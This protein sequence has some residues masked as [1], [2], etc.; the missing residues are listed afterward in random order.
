MK[1]QNICR[2]KL[3]WI[4]SFLHHWHQRLNCTWFTL[5]LVMAQPIPLQP[6]SPNKSHC[7]IPPLHLKFNYASLTL[8]HTTLAFV[9]DLS[10]IESILYLPSDFFVPAYS[11][12]WFWLIKS[13]DPRAWPRPGLLQPPSSCS[14]QGPLAGIKAAS[15]Q[16]KPTQME[17][18][19]S[20]EKRAQ[21]WK[22]TK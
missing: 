18:T 1:L 22:M 15:I 2:R 21:C 8:I 16:I 3:S 11:K 5:V 12:H 10:Q 20:K 9:L 4:F 14:P 7:H 6:W 19:V 17:F 13:Q